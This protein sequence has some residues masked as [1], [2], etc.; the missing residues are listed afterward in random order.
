MA[1][2]Q[3]KSIKFPGLNDVYTIPIV[4]TDPTLTQDGD[5]ADAKVVGEA[6]SD[7]RADVD[8]KAQIQIITW[9]ADD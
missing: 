2:K 1:E 7:I 6:I 3:L 9:G 8:Q 5:A 4:S